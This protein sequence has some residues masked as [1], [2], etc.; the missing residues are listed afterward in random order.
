MYRKIKAMLGEDGPR[1]VEWTRAS[2][3]LVATKEALL[4]HVAAS[5]VPCRQYAERRKTE[6]YDELDDEDEDEIILALISVSQSPRQKGL[7]TV[8]LWALT[9]AGRVLQ[10]SIHRH[11]NHLLCK[12]LLSELKSL[13]AVQSAPATMIHAPP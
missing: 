8:A 9:T 6:L 12:S 11:T 5:G 10:I 3:W 7:R 13:L 2:A 1:F 4:L